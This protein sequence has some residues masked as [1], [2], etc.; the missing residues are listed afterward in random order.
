MLHCSIIRDDKGYKLYYTG[1]AAPGYAFRSIGVALSQDGIRWKKH[2]GN[3]VIFPSRDI[4]S[5]EFDNVHC[6]IPTILYRRE[7]KPRY[8][9]WY[10]GY[11]NNGGNRIGYAHSDDG[12]HWVRHPRPV[13]GFGKPGDF[14]DGGLRG[15]NVIIHPETGAYW[16]Y[17]NGT[18]PGQHYGPTGLAVSKDG[19]HWEKRGKLSADESRLLYGEVV[20]DPKA[21][22]FRM[23]HDRGPAITYA[24]SRDGVRWQDLDGPPLIQPDK[25]YDRGYCQGPSVIYQAE[26]KSY[27]VYYNGAAAGYPATE[28]VTI[29]LAVF[30]AADLEKLRLL[31]AR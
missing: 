17:Y 4:K 31:P 24:V 21:K 13:L 23:W 26:S 2:A 29:N 8:Q 9:M 10:S 18:R 15:P 27:F 14:D 1:E 19:I 22:Q 30:P 11:Q 20:Y 25:P 5:G 12:L 16:M 28:R 7:G 6:H 3:P